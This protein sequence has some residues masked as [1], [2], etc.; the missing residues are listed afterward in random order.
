MTAVREPSVAVVIV[1]FEGVDALRKCLAALRAGTYGA[2][3]III[4]DN[5]LSDR[6]ER[7]FSGDAGLDYIRTGGNLGFSRG[8]NVGIAR[9]LERG[10]DYTW[11]LN[12]D[13]EPD[14][15]CLRELVSFA[16]KSD[17]PGIVG[18]KIR[19]ADGPRHLWYAGGRLS[20]AQG[21]GKHFGH[22][23]PDDGRF[24]SPAE[25][26]YATGCCMLIPNRVL[27]TVGPLK[28]S[29][30]MYL[31]DA[32]FS[33]RMRRA[34]YRIWYNPRATLSHV[35]NGLT[36]R[37]YPDYYL[38]FSVRN[39]PF[40]AQGGVYALYLHGVAVVLAAVKIL[41]YGLWPGVAGRAPRLRA[42]FWGAID[43]L[44]PRAREAERFPRLFGSR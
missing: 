12:P 43:S 10:D 28:E 22:Q 5:S 16:E 6:L 8:C 17:K 26:T 23:V 35:G 27:R 37:E 29:I 25:V 9:A 4:V 15:D 34:G 20:L 11:L 2:F 14:S 39:K 24:D 32:E 44:S 21:V 31:D 19:Y 36:W 1:G 30:F 42:L 13:A 7:E 33:L 38:Y 3:R 41:R 18:G 40:V